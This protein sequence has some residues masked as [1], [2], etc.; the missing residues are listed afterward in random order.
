MRSF[1]SRSAR[2]GLVLL[3]E[4]ILFVCSFCFSKFECMMIVSLDFI[5]LARLSLNETEMEG[6]ICYTY[7]LDLGLIRKMMM[8]DGYDTHLLHN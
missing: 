1:L 6:Y 7:C 4:L 3:F 5:Y 8:I 2:L